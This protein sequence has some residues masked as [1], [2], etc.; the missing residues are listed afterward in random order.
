MIEAIQK[1][2]RPLS[3]GLDEVLGRVFFAA[4]R[5][6]TLLVAV[7]IARIYRLYSY[8]QVYVQLCM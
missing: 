5:M 3:A 8:G 7:E 2:V 4:K 1:C 6:I